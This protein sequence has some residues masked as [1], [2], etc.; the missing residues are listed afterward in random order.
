[1]VNA[2]GPWSPTLPQSS[3]RLRPT[4]GVHLVI[5]R[6]RLP[7]P[8]AVVMTDGPRIL[9]AIP[10]GQRVI[11]GTTDTDYDGPLE[12]PRTE[13]DDIAYVL[14][15][16]NRT[17]PRAGLDRGDVRATWAGLRPLIADA[18]G[19]PSDISRAHE[20]HVPRPGWIDVAGGKLTTYRLIA[21]QVVDRA[22]RELNVKASPCRTAKEP[23]L[24]S[25][26]VAHSGIVP[27]EPSPEC[28]RHYCTDEWAVHLDDVMTRRT[29]WRYYRDD[30]SAVAE[31]VAG[32]M[33]E[34]LGWDAARTRSELAQYRDAPT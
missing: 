33:A 30:A 15:I 23:L 21:E 29:G 13:P 24:P 28:V 8:D 17:F 12:S 14:G 25:P 31:Q 34:V 22:L 6:G 16:V 18:Q 9:F 4:K 19:R 26:A 2:T 32:W 10:W 3:I 7:V 5:D 27:P 11:L 20:I 1:V